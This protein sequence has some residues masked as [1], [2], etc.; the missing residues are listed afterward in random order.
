[1]FTHAR[2]TSRLTAPISATNASPTPAG[3]T[4][5]LVT[6]GVA[7]AAGATGAGVPGSPICTVTTDDPSETSTFLSS[8]SFDAG[9]VARSEPARTAGV[10]AAAPAGAA[11]LTDAAP[12]LEL[13]LAATDGRVLAELDVDLAAESDEGELPDC[14]V[15]AEAVGAPVA[16][17]TPSPTT[18]A[19]A[20]TR[21]TNF[22]EDNVSTFLVGR[23][24]EDAASDR[25]G[26]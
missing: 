11:P 2:S 10:P 12:R 20:V 18:K 22:A 9:L 21:D 5:S 6:R 8:S 23:D 13:G 26:P 15:S 7:T 3:S 16:M 24:G 1:M 14:A 4:G 17:A 19:G 25:A